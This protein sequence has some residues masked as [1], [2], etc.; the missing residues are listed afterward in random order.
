M[1]NFFTATFNINIHAKSNGIAVEN[2]DRKAPE[3]IVA[4]WGDCAELQYC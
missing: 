1:T 3:C 4:T 2:I